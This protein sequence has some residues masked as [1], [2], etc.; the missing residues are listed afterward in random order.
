MIGVKPKLFHLRLVL[1]RRC[2]RYPREAI[3]RPAHKSRRMFDMLH[4]DSLSFPVSPSSVPLH[5][6]ITR[7]AGASTRRYRDISPI[8]HFGADLTL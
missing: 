8:S 3:G 6:P 7:G 2:D 4:A 5:T 1:W